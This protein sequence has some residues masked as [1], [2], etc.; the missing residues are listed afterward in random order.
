MSLANALL[1]PEQLAERLDLWALRR[2]KVLALLDVRSSRSARQLA[3]TCRVLAR[4][5]YES[6]VTAEAWEA[7]WLRVREEAAVVL[8]R[9]RPPV[10]SEPL[11]ES[12]PRS[13][14]G[15]VPTIIRHAVWS[16]QQKVA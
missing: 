5:S 4:S 9:A 2:E 16:A 8:S 11:E 14:T 10:M 3:R 12:G 13:T 15:V 1:R 6:S 7:E